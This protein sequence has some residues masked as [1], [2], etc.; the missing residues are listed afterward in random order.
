[1]HARARQF[2]ELD[3]ASA[4]LRFSLRGRR[5]GLGAWR[6]ARAP[7]AERPLSVQFSGFRRSEWWR[8]GCALAWPPV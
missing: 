4:I 6:A 7:Q 1:M 8:G 5:T 3:P 2:R